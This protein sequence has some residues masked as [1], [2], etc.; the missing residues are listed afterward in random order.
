[1]KKEK[2]LKDLWAD[3]YTEAMTHIADALKNRNDVKKLVATF[4]FN[5]NTYHLENTKKK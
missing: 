3:G 2:E 4:F 1:M 5:L